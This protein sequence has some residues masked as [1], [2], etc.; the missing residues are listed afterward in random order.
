MHRFILLLITVTALS[1]DG[2]WQQNLKP[3]PY[4]DEEAYNV[5]SALLPETQTS[6]L[7]RYDTVGENA[8]LSSVRD[9]DKAAAAALDDYVKVNRTAWALQDKFSLP[10]PPKLVSMDD[11]RAMDEEDQ[12]TGREKPGS[13]RTRPHFVLS[14]VGFNADKTIAVVWIYYDCGGLCGSGRLAVLRKAGER[15]KRGPGLRRRE[16]SAAH[17]FGSGF[18]PTRL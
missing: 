2:L 6:L 11:L 8:C 10:K 9:H 15:D 16:L 7:I 17:T 13:S 14:A 4:K 1:Q 3:E 18:P 12:R 5:Y